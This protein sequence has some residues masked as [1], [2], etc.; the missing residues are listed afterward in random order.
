MSGP[1]REV[2]LEI[3]QTPGGLDVRAIDADDGLEVSFIAPVNTPRAQI[4]TLALA[5]LAY[6]RRKAAGDDDDG[7]GG[8]G[9]G[10]GVIA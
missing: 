6:V 4:E 1:G 7:K 9:S 5:K 10:G 3:L 2:F 8:S